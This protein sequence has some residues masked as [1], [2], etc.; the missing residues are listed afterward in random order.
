MS[1]L[2]MLSC[3]LKR[4]NFDRESIIYRNG[5]IV[6]VSCTTGKPYFRKIYSLSDIGHHNEKIILRILEKF[7]HPNIV[8][9]LDNSS[10]YYTDFEKVEVFDNQKMNLG[11]SKL[12]SDI[13]Q[14]LKHLHK[15]GIV[16]I[17]LHP[18]NFGYDHKTKRWK[19]FDFDISGAYDFENH[20]QWILEPS[21]YY[22]DPGAYKYEYFDSYK[23]YLDIC[24]EPTKYFN[25]SQMKLYQEIDKNKKTKIDQ[26]LFLDL[27]GFSLSTSEPE[28]GT[29]S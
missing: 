17:D 28:I 15:L 9:I 14:A 23:R 20:N 22:Y 10:P 26:I 27:F 8:K 16:Y 4:D 12:Q 19:L 11:D 13:S 7:P 18:Y 1:F 2:N 24:K 25:Q 3:C 29:T 6:T 21:L 5:E